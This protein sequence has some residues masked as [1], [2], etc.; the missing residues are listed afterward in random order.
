MFFTGVSHITAVEKNKVGPAVFLL[1]LQASGW[2]A[3]TNGID[4]LGFMRYGGQPKVFQVKSLEDEKTALK[5]ALN[6]IHDADILVTWKGLG[7]RFITARA[8]HHR[9]D[10]TPLYEVIHLDLH[11]YVSEKMGFEGQ[12]I[13]KLSRFLGVHK[14]EKN[15]SKK[16]L[17]TRLCL[18]ELVMI[19]AVFG[20][21]LPLLRKTNPELAL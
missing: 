4:A 19:E 9:L 15:P 5:T 10:P 1:S 6:K 12:D 3:I 8:L 11:K 17:E 21:L 13:I 20:R 2:D 18:Q 14:P 16:T 7:I